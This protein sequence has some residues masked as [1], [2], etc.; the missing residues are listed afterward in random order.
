MPRRHH[1]TAVGRPRGV[2]QPLFGLEIDAL[3]MADVLERAKLATERRH[4]LLIGVVNAAKIVQ[5]RSDARLRASLLE[6]DMLLAD[7]QSV[8]WASRIL[9]RPLP[10]RVAGIDLFERLLEAADRDGLAVYFL[11]A[12]QNV[13]D[14]LL[15]AVRSRYPRLVVAGSRNGY[16]T[17]DEAAG[18]AAAIEQSR[19]DMLFLGM[20]SPVKE[21]FLAGYGDSMRVPLLHGVGGSFDV[22]AGI[23]KRAPEAWQRHGLEWAY[24]LLQEPRRLWKRYVTTNTAFIFL[25][26]RER[27]R[28]TTTYAAGRA[29]AGTPDERTE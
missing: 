4:R 25:T 10:E 13:L 1:P 5:M 12:R 20:P 15:R 7:G 26:L 14:K 19:A 11:G 3:T 8:I 22:L 24:R 16:F 2:R 28:P 27:I 9:G 17:E 29:P 23:T 21:N 6:A 18:V